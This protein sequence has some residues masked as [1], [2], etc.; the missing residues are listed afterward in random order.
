M[1]EWSD[2]SGAGEKRFREREREEGSGGSA[3]TLGSILEN[4]VIIMLLSEYSL[5]YC[6]K[7]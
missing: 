1:F 2:S 7:K 6:F 5:H 3:A 4:K